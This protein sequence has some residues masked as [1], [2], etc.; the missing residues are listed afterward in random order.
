MLKQ[1]LHPELQKPYTKDRGLGGE[2]G[3]TENL[4]NIWFVIPPA[5]LNKAPAGLK[6]SLLKEAHTVLAGLPRLDSLLNLD[7]LVLSLLVKREALQSSRIEGT[8][9]TIDQVL[10]PGELYD[11]KEKSARASVV[12]YAHAL[13]SAFQR[14]KKSGVKILTPLLIKKLHKE[15]MSHDPEYR[16]RPGVL[17]SETG[18]YATIGGL[19]RPENSTFNPA[20]PKH[21]KRTLEKNLSWLRDETLIEMSQAGMAPSLVVRLARGHWHFEAVHPF[22]D[23]NGRVGRM[24]LTLQMV[25][26]GYAPLYLS[27]YIE[28]YKQAYYEAL[29]QAQMKLR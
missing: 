8:F 24:L 12:G 1:H 6:T 11:K 21:V 22:S 5:P 17:R 7:R 3:K 28:A 18:V 9:S 26:E 4:R 29:K 14:A 2:I 19:G 27:G 23:G 25:C 15:M 16:G 13:E 20:P 10:T